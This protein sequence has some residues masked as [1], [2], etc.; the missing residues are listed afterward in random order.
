MTRDF[1]RSRSPY[2]DRYGFSRGVRIGDRIEIAGTAP[3]PPEGESLAP[4]AHDQMLRCG[5]IAVAALEDD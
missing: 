1:A 4:T 2:E 5:A 3:I